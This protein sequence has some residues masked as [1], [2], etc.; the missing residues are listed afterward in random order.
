MERQQ[1]NLQC[2]TGQDSSR[3]CELR[4]RLGRVDQ[5]YQ[6]LCRRI[7]RNENPR[8]LHYFVC[9]RAAKVERLKLESRDLE[10]FQKDLVDSI[11]A[12]GAAL[13]QRSAELEE[14]LRA[15]F[16]R[17][18]REQSTEARQNLLAEFPFLNASLQF[19]RDL[20]QNIRS[21]IAL[22]EQGLGRLQD[23]KRFLPSAQ[24]LNDQ[25]AHDMAAEAYH[26]IRRGFSSFPKE[27]RIRYEQL[28]ASIGSVVFPRLEGTD[29]CREACV[30]DSIFGTIGNACNDKLQG[31]MRVIDECASTSS[32]QL[33]LMRYIEADVTVILHSLVDD[34]ASLCSRLQAEE[35]NIFNDARHRVMQE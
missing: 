3:L 25:T 12:E 14:R 1:A 2:C 24:G 17:I 16:A 20:L 8:F 18:V 34:A 15:L 4:S 13:H 26:L 22:V 27:A 5:K 10:K 30:L 35:R 32:R 21:S 11:T 29:D 7:H 23:A 31:N 9:N 33:D 28:C 6:H 19:E